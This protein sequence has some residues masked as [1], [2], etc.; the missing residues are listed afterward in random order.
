MTNPND[1]NTFEL[2][3]EGIDVTYT[4]GS[5]GGIPRFL[6]R[7]ENASI[8]V[9]GDEIRARETELGT[10]VTVTLEHV[11]D[12]HSVR[13]TLLLP[14]INLADEPKVE[15]NTALIEITNRTT[16]GGPVFIVGPVQ[17]YRFFRLR[18]EATA[19]PQ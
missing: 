5:R 4:T 3:G 7:G 17:L 1:P 19:V 6:Y 16:I 13:V 2:N 9:V 11:P 10:E 18:G 8:D 15:F 14:K 12:L